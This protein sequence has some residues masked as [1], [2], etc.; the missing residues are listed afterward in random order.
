VTNGST[1]SAFMPPTALL[2]N[3]SATDDGEARGG[4]VL[5]PSVPS[6]AMDIRLGQAAVGIGCYLRA[7][8]G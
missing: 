7:P 8:G 5:L 1:W 2:L 3:G 4:L 6:F